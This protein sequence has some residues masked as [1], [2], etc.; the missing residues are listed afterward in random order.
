MTFYLLEPISGEVGTHLINISISRRIYV[1]PTGRIKNENPTKYGHLKPYC[2]VI[3]MDSP[4][5]SSYIFL[6]GSHDEC[7]KEIK[8]IYRRVKSYENVRR[9]INIVSPV[10]GAIV[11]AIVIFFLNQINAN[12]P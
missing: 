5:Q 3:E 2:I 10:I 9:I 12:N 11:G 4:D 6:D 8:K 7:S 1:S